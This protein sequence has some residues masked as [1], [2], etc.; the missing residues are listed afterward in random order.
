MENMTLDSRDSQDES[1]SEDVPMSFDE[2]QVGFDARGPSPGHILQAVTLAVTNE[3]FNLERLET[4]G[5]SFLKLAT[6]VHLYCNSSSNLHEGLLTELRS[7]RISNQNLHRLG[8]SIGL[9]HLMAAVQLNPSENWIPPGYVGLDSVNQV[10][11]YFD[12]FFL[13]LNQFN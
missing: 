9:P 3:A 4:V 6:S 7:K 5:D 1:Q 10:M 8:Q 13:N 2:I 11:T 12:V